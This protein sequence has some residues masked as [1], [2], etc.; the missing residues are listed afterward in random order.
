M[1]DKRIIEVNIMIT[2]IRIKII[3][4]IYITVIMHDNAFGCTPPL[5]IDPA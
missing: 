3:I 5:P 2:Y 4:C 1:I